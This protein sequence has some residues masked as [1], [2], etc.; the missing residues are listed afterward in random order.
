MKKLSILT[1]IILVLGIAGNL[2]A[3]SPMPEEVMP[4]PTADTCAVRVIYSQDRETGMLGEEMA[5]TLTFAASMSKKDVSEKI[6][7]YIDKKLKDGRYQSLQSN[8]NSLNI[9]LF[10]EVRYAEC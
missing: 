1:L 6:K 5:S 7:A 4:G 9:N 2:L 3:T 8:A 10:E